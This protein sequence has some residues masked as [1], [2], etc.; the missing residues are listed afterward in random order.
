MDS[1]AD[2]VEEKMVEALQ[3]EVCSR[4]AESFWWETLLMLLGR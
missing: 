1:Q 4:T 2:D 3:V